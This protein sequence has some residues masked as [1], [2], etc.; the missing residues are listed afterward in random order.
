MNPSLK[1]NAAGTWL[2]IL[3]N[4]DE[5]NWHTLF[6][7]VFRM[8]SLAIPLPVKGENPSELLIDVY[9]LLEPDRPVQEA[10]QRAVLSFYDHIVARRSFERDLN[11]F[12]ELHWY[13]GRLKGAGTFELL[14]RH[15]NSGKF[16]KAG[17]V[18]KMLQ[19]NLLTMLKDMAP[20]VDKQD[21]IWKYLQ[22]KL[23]EAPAPALYKIAFS[24]YNQYFYHTHFESLAWQYAL[25]IQ[26]EKEAQVLLDAWRDYFYSYEGLYKWLSGFC[27]DW[28]DGN[29]QGLKLFRQQLAEYLNYESSGVKNRTDPYTLLTLAI[30]NNRRWLPAQLLRDLAHIALKTM[31]L[32]KIKLQAF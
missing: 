17:A 22:A 27:D 23:A 21:F 24:F 4:Y 26:T 6:H 3:R 11:Y 30:L 28:W 12:V 16:E 14:F 31:A 20:S 1:K 15:L 32:S 25:I 5:M 8:G 19:V 2:A 9:D 7:E 13:F 10:F 18:G 29:T